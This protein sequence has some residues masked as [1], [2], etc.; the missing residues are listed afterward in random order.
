[1]RNLLLS[2]SA[3]F[4]ILAPTAGWAAQ[5]APQYVSSEPADG[6]ELHQA[7][8]EVSATFSEP[9]D[10][11]SKLKVEDHCGNRLDDR[12]VEVSANEMS[13]GIAKTPGGHYMV[14]YAAVGLGG[15]TG[16][17]LGQF[18]FTV[19]AGKKCGG[20]GHH[21]DDGEHGDHGD[22]GHRD[23]EHTGGGEHTRDHGG[24]GHTEHEGGAGH[25]SGHMGAE[26]DDGHAD[27]AHTDHSGAAATHG[28][29]HEDHVAAERERRTKE[30]RPTGIAT[31]E[32]PFPELAPDSTAVLLS[33]ILCI[34]FGGLGGFL[35]R[36]RG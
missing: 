4:L 25:V 28:Q 1:M 29:G 7:P 17:N 32:S 31:G 30:R 10:P 19:H 35:L 34:A 26:H 23:G 9:L 13:V 33:L 15:I 21:I 5:V 11:S 14:T 27:T 3:A 18:S 8:E 2:L 12:K 6:E 24:G 20:G 22:G 36:T 16:T